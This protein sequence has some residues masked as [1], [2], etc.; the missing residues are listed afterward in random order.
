MFKTVR[1]AERDAFFRSAQ[2]RFG[3]VTDDFEHRPEDIRVGECRRMSGFA[4]ARVRLVDKLPCASDVADAPS[5]ESQIS[6]LRRLQILTEAVPGFTISL[7]VVDSQ[8]LFA[9]HPRVLEIALEEA[10]QS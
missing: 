5:R 6:G 10:S 8:R 3:V 2:G 7:G 4:C 1:S 9:M